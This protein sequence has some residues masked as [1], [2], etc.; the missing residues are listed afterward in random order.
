MGIGHN[1]NH[2]GIGT[3]GAKHDSRHH[4]HFHSH[5]ADP[6]NEKRMAIAAL[7]T[8]IF[9][10]VEVIGG[11]ISGSLALIA[12]AG[13]MMTDC[14]ALSLAWLGFRMA[15]RPADWKRTFGFDRFAILAAF[16]NG[17]TL[18]VVAG[19]IIIEAIKR[20]GDPIEVMGLPMLLVASFGMV[21]N[22]LVFAILMS[23]DRDNLNIRGAV[24]H[25]MGDLLGSA[26]AIFAAIVILLTGWMPVD[27][28]VSILVA[29]LILRSAWYVVKQSGHIL[30][31]GA[32][33]GLDRRAI[34]ADLRKHFPQILDVDHIHAWSISQERPMVTLEA[35]ITNEAD[36]ETTAKAIKA[37]LHEHFGV[38]HATIEVHKKH[39]GETS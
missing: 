20:F 17:L 25:V 3:S 33:E 37:H 6:K 24:I 35:Y 36:I 7:L 4:N 28:I 5:S 16:I 15:R 27:M 19:W 2:G 22:L 11:Y 10:V 31:E 12:D 26:A 1:H 9:M 14:A 34:S 18:F 32:P 29:L 38:E 30:L 13:H 23:A 39:T 8:G 21:V